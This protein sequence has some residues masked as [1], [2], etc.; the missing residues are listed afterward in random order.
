M[1][2]TTYLPWNCVWVLKK[3]ICLIRST[4]FTNCSTIKQLLFNLHVS[5]SKGRIWNPWKPHVEVKF[6]CSHVTMQARFQYCTGI[7]WEIKFIGPNNQGAGIIKV[8][9]CLCFTCHCQSE[10]IHPS[11]KSQRCRAFWIPELKSL[12]MCSWN[13]TWSCVSLWLMHSSLKYLNILEEWFDFLLH[14][15]LDF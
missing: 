3:V 2:I 4:A 10:T 1:L 12:Q 6:T 7:N 11:G 15:V 14:S 13:L 8:L 5:A 9:C